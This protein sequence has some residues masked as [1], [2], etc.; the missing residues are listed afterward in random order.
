MCVRIYVRHNVKYV[1]CKLPVDGV[2]LQH[3]FAINYK[4]VQPTYIQR[5]FCYSSFERQLQCSLLVCTV[6]LSSNTLTLQNVCRQKTVI[7]ISV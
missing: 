4:Y 5:Y 6:W 7:I 2:M 1:L 3:V